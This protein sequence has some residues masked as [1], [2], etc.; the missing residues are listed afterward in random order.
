MPVYDTT[1]PYSDPDVA[2]DVEKGLARD[3]TAWVKERGGVEEYDGRDVKPE[4]NG[5]VSG[6][7][8]AR[9]YPVVNKPLRAVSPSSPSPLW[10]GS[11]SEASRGG[12]RSNSNGST[13]T[14]CPLPTTGEG[15]GESVRPLPSWSGRGAA[16]S[17]R[18]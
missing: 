14:L 16:S 9:V 13:P 18:R 1:G 7:H 11:A 4:D 8:A 3:R 17:P 5:N 15:N 12:G 6:K 10:G 2:I